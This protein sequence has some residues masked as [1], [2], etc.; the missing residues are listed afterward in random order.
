[1][2]AYLGTNSEVYSDPDAPP[3][4]DDPKKTD[5]DREK[6]I[7]P[8]PEAELEERGNEWA[9]WN[10]RR[11]R[12]REVGAIVP[13]GFEDEDEDMVRKVRGIVSNDKV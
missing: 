13:G 11:G 2:G 9:C 1:M 8:E 12:V 10:L 7:C 6:G 3:L 5:D 4:S